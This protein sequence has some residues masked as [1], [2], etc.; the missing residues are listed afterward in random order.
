MNLITGIVLAGGKSKRMG[1]DKTFAKLNGKPLIQHALDLLSPFCNHII[2]SSN[3]PELKKFGFPV[4][5]DDIPDCGPIGG[6]YSCLK[7]SETEWNLILSVDSPKVKPEFIQLLINQTKNYDAIVPV[8]NN[9]KEPL[10]A[11]YHKKSLSKIK[12]AINSGAYKM[13]SLLSELQ[14]NYVDAQGWVNQFPN[15]FQN[16][17]KQE[18]L[19][20]K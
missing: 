11:L 6:I 5:H 20:L 19:G 7:K 18:D 9:G 16:I 3:N 8:H 4:I 12:K 17:N 10:I 14:V 15:I 2:I 13:H 1:T